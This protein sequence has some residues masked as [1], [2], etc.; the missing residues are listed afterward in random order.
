[1]N[2]QATTIA[3]QGA[4][5]IGAAPARHGATCILPLIA[6]GL[7]VSWLAAIQGRYRPGD[8]FGY[9]LGVTGGLMMLA[10]LLYPLRKHLRF[11]QHA[12][13][14]RHW[15]RLHMAFGVLGPLLIVIHS[16]YG[17]GSLNAGVAMACM[18]LVAGSG[19]VGRFIY[20]RIHHGLYGHK[21]TVQERLAELGIH[22]DEV[23]SKFHFAPAVEQR[24]RAFN[25]M[26]QR[27]RPGLA[28]ATWQVMTIG[29]RA[30]RARG[31]CRRELRKILSHHARQRGWERGKLRQRLEAADHMV[32]TYIEAVRNAAQF[33]IY[34][35]LFSLWHI[36]HVPFVFMLAISG[37]VHVIAVHMY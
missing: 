12:G 22:A 10:L 36:L 32:R 29:W 27:P 9:Y 15:F 3:A 25:D 14:I 18:L 17:I 28:A 23:K 13:A 19:V 4:P 37:V 20:T 31:F 7:A 2:Q 34:E 24:L 35:R 5:R 30:R 8:D 16:A 1:M 26:A 21:A 6:I 33:G 11:L